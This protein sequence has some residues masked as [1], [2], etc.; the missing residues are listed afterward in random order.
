MGI[1]LLCFGSAMKKVS[2]YKELFSFL[3]CP[4]ALRIGDY[5]SMESNVPAGLTELIVFTKVPTVILF[6]ACYGEWRS[7]SKSSLSMDELCS[8]IVPPSPSETRASSFSILS[9]TR[10]FCLSEMILFSGINLMS[11]WFSI[12]M[13]W[14]VRA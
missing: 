5:A 4:V 10:V 14:A 12:L 3:T 8:R 1:W 9:T 2:S 13:F 11:F 6:L 7:E